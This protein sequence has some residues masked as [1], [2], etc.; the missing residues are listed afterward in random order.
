VWNDGMLCAGKL[1]LLKQWATVHQ[2]LGVSLVK[3]H[4][5][6]QIKPFSRA[7]SA[8]LRINV[9]NC[10]AYRVGFGFCSRTTLE[11]PKSKNILN[12]IIDLKG[13]WDHLD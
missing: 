9:P 11:C 7:K 2:G 6:K 13:D 5:T 12:H 4:K 10:E 3:L 8:D 1:R